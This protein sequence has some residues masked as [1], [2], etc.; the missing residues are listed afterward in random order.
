MYVQEADQLEAYIN[1]L[2]PKPPAFVPSKA[3]GALHWLR[4][5]ARLARGN[6]PA[7]EDLQPPSTI[8]PDHLAALLPVLFAFLEKEK[9]AG[10]F[11]PASLYLFA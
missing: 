7:P 1:N 11:D 6:W 9:E 2:Y 4:F 3:Y 10:L 8:G 5:L